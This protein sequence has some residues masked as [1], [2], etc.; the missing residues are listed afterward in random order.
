MLQLPVLGRSW[1]KLDGCIERIQEPILS[2]IYK[3]GASISNNT[4]NIFLL[5]GASKLAKT[6]ISHTVASYF[7][8]QGRLGATIFFDLYHSSCQTFF[9]SIIQELCRYHPAIYEK[10]M[11]GLK[12]NAKFLHDPPEQ[13]FNFLVTYVF[14]SLT[15]IG[16]TLIIVDNLN[17]CD[18]RQFLGLLRLFLKFPSNI[19]LL[20]TSEP[21]GDIL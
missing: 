14:E 16:P 9:P 11:T 21:E 1:N 19:R 6:A 18:D 5:L 2:K 15:M 7:D 8:E 17:K 10:V 3:W 13:Q 20:I 4:P 12:K